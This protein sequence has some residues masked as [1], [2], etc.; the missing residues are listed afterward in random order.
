M[1]ARPTDDPLAKLKN[2]CPASKEDWEAF[3]NQLFSEILKKQSTRPG[4]DKNFVP[5]FTRLVCSGIRDVDIRKTATKLREL[6]EEKVRE[7]K[8]AKKGG[9]VKKA[10]KPK[11][12][13]TASAK[14]T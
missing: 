13:G 6:A 1:H 8:E 7:E 12:V 4:Y 10:A 5:H 11:T 3:S 14:N 2:A 9:G